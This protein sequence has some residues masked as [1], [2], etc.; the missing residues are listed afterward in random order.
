MVVNWLPKKQ[1]HMR[2]VSPSL[3][4]SNLELAEAQFTNGTAEGKMME[5][6]PRGYVIGYPTAGV[7][8]TGAPSCRDAFPRHAM[9][10]STTRSFLADR[11]SKSNKC[12]SNPLSSGA[13]S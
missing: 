5:F 2:G 12:M 6:E 4:L 7:P 10:C 11:T 3:R 8:A 1:H 13:A 9:E